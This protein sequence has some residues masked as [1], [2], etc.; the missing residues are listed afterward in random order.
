MLNMQVDIIRIDRLYE[1]ELEI[2]NRINELTNG[3][4]EVVD[5]QYMNGENSGYGYSHYIMILYK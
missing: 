5:V 2:N 3:G 4:Y 1:A